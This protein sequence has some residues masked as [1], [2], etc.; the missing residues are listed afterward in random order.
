MSLSC[1]LVQGLDNSQCKI[2][3]VT[4]KVSNLESKQYFNKFAR[5]SLSSSDILLTSTS[6]FPE[7]EGTHDFREYPEKLKFT[8]TSEN[9]I[10]DD[11]APILTIHT[12]KSVYSILKNYSRVVARITTDLLSQSDLLNLIQLADLTV[13]IEDSFQETNYAGADKSYSLVIRSRLKSGHGKI[14]SSVTAAKVTDYIKAVEIKEKSRVEQILAKDKNTEEEQV[15]VTKPSL[16]VQSSFS[17]NR[18]DH[19]E[20][21]RQAVVLPHE[22]AKMTISY[23]PEEDDSFDDSDPDDDLDI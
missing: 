2:I 11:L 23:Q 17:M 22:T 16:E 8:K 9:L 1:R 12:F 13:N 15:R 10:V 21:A 3:F 5:Q 14:V 6:V 18:K 19:E 20:T 7:D 4:D